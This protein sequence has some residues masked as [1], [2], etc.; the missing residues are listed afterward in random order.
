M[1]HMMSSIETVPD[2]VDVAIIGGGIAGSALAIT[3]RRQGLEV[4][5]VEREPTF[6]DRVRGEAIH[7]WG[8]REINALGLRL[9]LQKAG[10]IELPYWT[11]YRDRVPAEPHAW[12]SDVPDSPPEISVGHP[13]LQE[14]LIAAAAREGAHVLRPATASPSPSDNGWAFEVTAGDATCRVTARLLVGADG[15]NSATRRLI[16]GTTVRDRIHHQFGGLLASGVDLP[17]DSAHQ[18]F[19]DGGFAMVFP[20]GNDKARIYLA[21]PN[22]LQRELLGPG[23]MPE[24]LRRAAACFPEGAFTRA[25]PAGPM[26]FFPNAD[27][28]VDKIAGDH[29][30][31]IGDA[32]GANDPT[33][34]HGLSLVFRD[35]RVLSDLMAE[36]LEGAPERFAEARRAYYHVLRTHAAWSAPLL[37]DTGDVA[38][39]LREQVRMAREVDPSAEGY[40]NLFSLGPDGL[41]TDD[42]TRRRFYGEHLPDAR[43]HTAAKQPAQGGLVIGRPPD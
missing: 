42:E 1:S 32:A 4:L 30:V 23:A 37:A 15:K 7:P 36:D 43:V 33:Q 29:V 16:G 8:V 31:L 9:L 39:A 19:Y 34:G 2:A 41:A 28:P 10:A 38:D 26:A 21:G 3:L 12:A 40:G 20:Q 18:G 5:V 11:T 14:V 35:V 17:K 27:V 13:Q 24:F 22:S 25:Q 6:R